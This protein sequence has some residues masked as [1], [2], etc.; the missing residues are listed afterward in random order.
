MRIL[1][2]S[3]WHLG[4]TLCRY[5]RSAEQLDMLAQLREI[6]GAHRP[7]VMIVAGD[8]FHNP[9]PPVGAQTMLASF[10]TGLMNENPGMTT[11]IT[12]GNHDSAARHEIFRVPWRQ[13]GI[14]A[15]GTLGSLDK[16]IIEIPDKGFVVAVPYAHE[17]NLP[18]EVFS[19]LL[20]QTARR[21]KQGLP[22]VL[23]AHL[24]VSGC[25]FSGHDRNADDDLSAVGGIDCRPLADFGKGYDYL[26]LGHIHR[27][28]SV[29]GSG[30][31]A[32]YSGTP[33]PVSFDEPSVH[34]VTIADI[35]AHGAKP[36][37]SEIEIGNPYPLVTLPTSGFADW[38]RAKQ[39]LTDFPADI[40]AYLRLNVEIDDFLPAGA[41]AEARAIAEKKACRFCLINTRRK[42]RN[43][44]R[45][46]RGITIQEFREE[47]PIEIARR[48]AADAGIEFDAELQK[49]FAEIVT[50]L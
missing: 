33:L 26:A 2:T 32:R 21:N 13:F 10:L 18:P 43:P 40:P 16:H 27:S 29:P 42:D 50:G 44:E 34:S 6:V 5:D 46:E 9:Q 12:A 49:L 23:T 48:Y 47:A 1:H 15:V 39:L 19:K 41:E 25:D 17:R 14:H 45:S 30:G 8:I 20:D 38:E 3:D 7:D 37:I 24:A 4:H 36:E 31:R 11:V 28:Q 35:P 22:V